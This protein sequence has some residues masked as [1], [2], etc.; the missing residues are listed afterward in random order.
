MLSDLQI[1]G[2]SKFSVS[3][4]GEVVAGDIKLGNGSANISSNLVIGTG[5]LS[6]NTVGAETTALGHGSLAANTTGVNN[7]AVG[8]N[9]LKANTTGSSNVS[10]GFN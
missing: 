9:S 10:V 8:N 7:V 1:G 5:S 2:V 4:S 3:K 6:N